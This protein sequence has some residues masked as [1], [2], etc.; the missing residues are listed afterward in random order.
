M[1]LKP[2]LKASEILILTFAI[3]LEHLCKT[4][5]FLEIK[6]KLRKLT[7]EVIEILNSPT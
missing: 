3:N 5:N 7:C 2:V 4:D 6:R 1:I